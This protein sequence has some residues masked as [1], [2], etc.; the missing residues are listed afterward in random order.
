[1]NTFVELDANI[2]DG[3]LNRQ[4]I[5]NAGITVFVPTGT[6]FD[7]AK[8]MLETGNLSDIYANHVCVDLALNYSLKS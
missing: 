2:T 6:A 7:A 5:D 8:G 3:A 4:S 1:L